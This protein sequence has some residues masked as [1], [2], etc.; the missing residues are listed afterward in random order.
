MVFL[1]LGNFDLWPYKSCSYS[2]NVENFSQWDEWLGPRGLKVTAAH[3]G[4]LTILQDKED[5]P[6]T[7]PKHI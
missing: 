7:N 4:R 3:S 6:L 1:G 2:M 5:S